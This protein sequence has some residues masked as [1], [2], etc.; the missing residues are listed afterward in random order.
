VIGHFF[1]ISIAIVLLFSFVAFVME[2][3]R[4]STSID[5]NEEEVKYATEWDWLQEIYSSSSIAKYMAE[6]QD[7]RQASRKQKKRERGHP[8]STTPLLGAGNRTVRYQGIPWPVLKKHIPQLAGFLRERRDHA[9][10]RR[11]HTDKA[12]VYRARALG[13]RQKGVSPTLVP[14]TCSPYSFSFSL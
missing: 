1:L 5:D 14:E 12:I 4:A 3:A 2:E 13:K 11:H 6:L 10:D 7:Q 8:S 9:Y